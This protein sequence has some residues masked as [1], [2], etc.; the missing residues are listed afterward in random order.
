MS[1]PTKKKIT[2][3]G[4]KRKAESIKGN[5]S[6]SIKKSKTITAQSKVLTSKPHLQHEDLEDDS[7]AADSND[8]DGAEL[9]DI[10][11]SETDF[12]PPVKRAKGAAHTDRVKS[13]AGLNCIL[14]CSIGIPEH[15]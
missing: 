4:T 12:E 1:P 3:A 11:N 10:D 15:Y 8:D 5:S 6:R 13:G 7:S 14:D 9:V 2:M